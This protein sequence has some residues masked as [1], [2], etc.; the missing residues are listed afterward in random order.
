MTDTERN[1][2]VIYIYIGMKCE[3]K[4]YFRGYIKAY[5]YTYVYCR[6]T[7]GSDRSISITRTIGPFAGCGLTT[8]LSWPLYFAIHTY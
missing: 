5:I 1:R 6:K 3:K 7:A 4:S 2:S 8:L